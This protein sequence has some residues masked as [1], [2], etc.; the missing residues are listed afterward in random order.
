MDCCPLVQAQTNHRA[1]FPLSSP[2]FILYDLPFPV[3]GEAQCV[4]DS[5]LN[6]RK[7]GAEQALLL[8]GRVC[9]EKWENSRAFPSLPCSFLFWR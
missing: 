5:L 3:G 7:K 4:G 6:R 8:G 9:Q 1:K 2:F